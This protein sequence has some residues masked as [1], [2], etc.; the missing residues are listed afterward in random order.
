ML[1]LGISHLDATLDYAPG[2]F[3]TEH[4]DSVI[5]DLLNCA[6]AI[7][8][9]GN[10]GKPGVNGMGAG[11][12]VMKG[13]HHNNVEGQALNSPTELYTS[14]RFLRGVKGFENDGT[15]KYQNKD[16]NNHNEYFGATTPLTQ[17]CAVTCH[18]SV[19]V[20][21]PNNTMSGFCATCHG[22]FHVIGDVDSNIDG[23]GIGGDINSPFTRHPTDVKFPSP[24]TEYNNYNPGGGGVYNVE[25]PVARGAIV[26]ISSVVDTT[27]TGDTGAIVMCLSCYMAHASDFPDMLRWDYSLMTIGSGRTDGCFNCHTTKN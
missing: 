11:V 26:G 18:S 21:P 17:G 24:G 9:H 12:Q 2:W 22:S 13:A 5:S 6:G 25:A 15:Y 7:G 14:Y 19:G 4:Y 3:P 20:W 16:E 23:E 1:D 10:R 27:T 8:C